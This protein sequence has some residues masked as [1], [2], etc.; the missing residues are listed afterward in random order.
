MFQPLG[1]Q[2]VAVLMVSDNYVVNRY[3]VVPRLPGGGVVG[4]QESVQSLEGEEF[5]SKY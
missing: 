1:V 5:K 2:N 4:G 3:L